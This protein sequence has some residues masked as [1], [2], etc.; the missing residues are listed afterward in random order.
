MDITTT[1]KGISIHFFSK[2]EPNHIKIRWQRSQSITTLFNYSSVEIPKN[3]NR[4]IKR[5][6]NLTTGESTEELVAENN[7]IMMYNPTLK[8]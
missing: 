8:E 3:Y 1:N 6:T 2:N 5:I 7:A 4:N